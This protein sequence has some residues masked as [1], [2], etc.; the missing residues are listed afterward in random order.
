MASASNDSADAGTPAVKGTNTGARPGAGVEGESALGWAV[1]G[2]SISGRGVVATSESDYGCRAH[3]K[4]SAGLRASSDES[5]GLEGWST[6]A[7][8]VH[9][10]S[11]TGNGVWGVTKSGSGVVGTSDSGNGGWFETSQGEGVRGTS[12]NA[13]HGGVVAV[14]TAGGIAA[15]G[16]SDAGVG[17]W[18]T[19]VDNEGVHAETR[20]TSTAALAAIQTNASSDSAAFFAKHAGNKNAAYFEGNVVVSGDITFLNAADCAEDFDIGVG[21]AAAP[22]TVMTL[23]DDGTLR[24]CSGSYDKRVAGVVSGAGGY[25]PG[26]ILDK[27]SDSP[28]RRPVALMGKVVC[29]ADAQFGPIAV[30]DLL[31]T[32][33]TPGHAMR[34]DD[35][36]RA[37]GAVLGKALRPLASGQGMI[38]ILVTLQ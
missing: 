6:K 23:D 10:I 35:S 14:N 29:K 36:Q 3:S 20:S 32:S 26:L 27:Q 12:K 2:H 28:D 4:T 30:G 37:F 25:K 13:G 7:E 33:T 11:E 18:G 19:S 34:A 5:R 24:E 21:A 9:G 38:P 8:G 31:T 17:V 1:Y 16:T 15:Y 22:G